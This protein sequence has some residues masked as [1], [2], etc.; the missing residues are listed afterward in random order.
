MV[1]GYA[2]DLF[3]NSRSIE[4]NPEAPHWRCFFY[5]PFSQDDELK[6]A[7]WANIKRALREANGNK[8]MAARKLG[9]SRTTLWRKL[10]SFEGDG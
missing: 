7:E 8:A 10:R 5:F 1:Y 2:H 3:R 6:K 4:R 9:I